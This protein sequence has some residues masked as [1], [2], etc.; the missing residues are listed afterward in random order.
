LQK[1]K[2]H[3]PL[4][5][6]KG[7]FVS[8]GNWVNGLDSIRFILAMVVF[9][10]HLDNAPA[11]FFKSFDNYFVRWIGIGINHIFLGPGA[12]IAFFIISGFVIHYP[13]KNS[14]LQVKS[15][16]VRRWF[17]IGL[18]LLA[19]VLF[20]KYFKLFWLIPIW[21]LYCELIYYTLYPVLRKINLTWRIQF[22][23]SFIVSI[24][25]VFLVADG[26]IKSMLA[27]TNINYTGSYAAL[28]N[29]LTWIVGLPCWLLGV[30]LADRIDSVTRYVST[31]KVNFVR[32]LMLIFSI[33]LVGLKSHWFVSYIITLNFFAFVLTYW[34]ENEIIY[35]RSHRSVR[36]MEWAGKFSYS[37]YLIHGLAVYFILHYIKVNIFTYS[38]FI[39]VTLLL[40]FIVYLIVEEPSHRFSKYL[41][42]RVSGL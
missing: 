37:L 29:W 17:R 12:V 26:E 21:S 40:A 28:G 41:A 24:G 7:D 13:L 2:I 23:V 31:V 16:L 30:W 19:V 33:L 10:S 20:S 38:F 35:F 14:P 4:L 36:L 25:L 18:P 1:S 39:L 5:E 3:K 27:R 42:R 15:F 32:V 6:N 11:A 22:I 34:L 9:L 8:K